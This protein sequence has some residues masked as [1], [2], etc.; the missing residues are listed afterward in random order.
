[1]RILLSRS[2]K[3][4]WISP[5][6]A[7][8]LPGCEIDGSDNLVRVPDQGLFMYTE[9]NRHLD[10]DEAQ[11]AAAVYKDGTPVALVAGDVFEAR[12]LT[13]RVLLTGRGLVTG[14]Y[15]ASLPIDDSVQAVFFNIVHAPIEAREQRWYP[16][17]LVNIDPGPGELVGKSASVS[18]PPA[19]TITGPAEDA[20]YTSINDSI[21]LS[22]VAIAEGDVMRVLSAVECTNGFAK[23]S[24]GT[25]VE[26]GDDDGYEAIGLD[27]FIYD[28]NLGSSTLKFI[29][30]A[31]L[32]LLQE[33]LN[34]LS[35][36]GIDPDFVLRSVD[37]NPIE[38]ACQIRLFLQRQRRGSF[39]VAFDDGA[40]FGARSAELT[41]DY[42]P[43]VQAN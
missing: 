34:D 23:S 14:S 3:T 18:F 43:P 36:G 30:D 38:S 15:A 24:Y 2:I 25:V 13:E 11:I 4:V 20:V 7:L 12:T 27:K 32:M 31:A 6:F 42:L 10:E 40:V 19:V 41:V 22:W 29:S 1:M 9:A 16:I 33:L 39:D 5:L 17:D 21:D 28:V 8:I 35:A 37:A 26:V